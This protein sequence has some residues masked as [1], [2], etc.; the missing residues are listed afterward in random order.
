MRG[1]RVDWSAGTKEFGTDG[2]L[3]G[4]FDVNSASAPC[5]ALVIGSRSLPRGYGCCHRLNK[6]CSE[7]LKEIR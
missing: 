1:F 7:P 4:R 3:I 5:R 2:S 6:I